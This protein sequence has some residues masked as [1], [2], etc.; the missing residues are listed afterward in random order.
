VILQT[1]L[2]DSATDELYILG[3]YVAPLDKWK[4]FDPR[5]FEL[6]KKQPRLG[7]YRTSDA[8]SLS[9]KGQFR[10]FNEQQRD[11][12]ITELAQAIPNDDW[13]YAVACYLSKSDFETYCAPGFHPAWRDPYYSCATFLI[14][15]LC[16]ELTCSG[17][18][19]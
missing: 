3:G 11:E 19:T 9:P 16:A 13:C 1:F 8:L 14:G 4:E 2:D 6:L 7:F 17:P 18:I 15:K 12:R 10:H 5:W